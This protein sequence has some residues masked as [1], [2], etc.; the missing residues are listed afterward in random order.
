MSVDATTPR[1]GRVTDENLA[2]EAAR[3]RAALGFSVRKMAE[4]TGVHRDSIGRIERGDDTLDRFTVDRY[5]SALDR[6]EG[7]LGMDNPDHVINVIELADGTKVTF[8]GTSASVADAAA[9][10]LANRDNRDD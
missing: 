6:L 9:A 7:R 5:L 1:V 8:T 4:Q 2:A 3:R 10:F